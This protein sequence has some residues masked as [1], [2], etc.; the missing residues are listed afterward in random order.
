MTARALDESSLI[1]RFGP[2]VKGAVAQTWL[3]KGLGSHRLQENPR[4]T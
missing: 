4:T 1:V 2:L 3:V